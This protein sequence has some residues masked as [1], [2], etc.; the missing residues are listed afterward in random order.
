VNKRYVVN[1]E[2][3]KGPSQVMCFSYRKPGHY[4]NC[5]SKKFDGRD[6]SL[7]TCFKCGNQGHYANNYPKTIK[8]NGNYNGVGGF[9]VARTR[10]TTRR[11]QRIRTQGAI[12]VRS[13]VRPN[14]VTEDSTRRRAHRTIESD[15]KLYPGSGLS[16]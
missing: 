3:Q 1:N 14:T 7:V 2:P 16:W 5:C 4:A 13:R 10:G 6:I 11:T 15:T 8:D 9:H 12:R